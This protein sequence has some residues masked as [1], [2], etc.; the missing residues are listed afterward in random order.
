MEIIINTRNA[1]KTVSFAGEELHRYL[2]RMLAG[3]EG[4]FSVFLGVRDG[5]EEKMDSYSVSVTG[6]GGRILGSN[7][8]SVLL[9]VYDYL[10]RLGCRFLGPGK[11]MEVV[12]HIRPGDLPAEYSRKASFLHRGVC[13]EGA[14]SA[15]NVLDFIDWLPKVGY[16]SFF[17]QF[18]VPYVFLARWYHHDLNPFAQPETFTMAEA[19]D[20][21][22]LFAAAM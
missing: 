14:D 17:L 18:Q 5:A 20:C 11:A 13:I 16:N 19:E 10:R 12:P 1:E 7:P 3:E 22:A 21:C 15:G 8:R 2:A 9:G 4:V 6:S